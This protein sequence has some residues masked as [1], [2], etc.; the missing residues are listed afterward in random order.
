MKKMVLIKKR[1]NGYSLLE[2][3]ITVVIM[4]F[5]LIGLARLQM[6]SINANHTANLRT[7]ATQQAYDMA[8]RMRAN[9]QGVMNGNY[10]NISESIPSDPVCISSGCTVAQMATYDAFQWNSDNA[11][12][13]APLGRGSV[14]RSGKFFIVTVR[15]DEDRTGD[16]NQLK[17]FSVSFEP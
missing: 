2:V 7:I 4:S 1:N 6:K 5:S 9:M 11:A 17:S 10:D 3:L 14:K 16:V 13:L 8:D 12:V 15:W